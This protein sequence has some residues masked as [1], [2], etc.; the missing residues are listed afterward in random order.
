MNIKEA[1]EGTLIYRSLKERVKFAQS[2]D[3]LNKC[4]LTK[5]G[6]GIISGHKYD[7]LSEEAEEAWVKI[8][9]LRY[10]YHKIEHETLG[11]I[12]FCHMCGSVMFRGNKQ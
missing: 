8:Y 4:K 11:S 5:C 2:I 10:P 7:V 1:L 12:L 3:Q 9:D 6:I